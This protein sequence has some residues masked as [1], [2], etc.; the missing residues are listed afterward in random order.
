MGGHLLQLGQ[1]LFQGFGM[2]AEAF[3]PNGLGDG[4]SHLLSIELEGLPA[5]HHD[6]SAQQVQTLDPGGSLVNWMDAR[7]PVVLF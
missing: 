1:G 4:L 5:L 2:G 3:R 7:I 6:L